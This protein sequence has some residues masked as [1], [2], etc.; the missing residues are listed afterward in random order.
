MGLTDVLIGLGIGHRCKLR[1]MYTSNEYRTWQCTICGS[2][3]SDKYGSVQECSIG[4][5]LERS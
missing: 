2:Y 4:D 1:E 3:Y 5:V